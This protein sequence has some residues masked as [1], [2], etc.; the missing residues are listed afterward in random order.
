MSES[1]SATHRSS[2][3]ASIKSDLTKVDAH[4]I[5]AEEY[6]EI[7]ELTDEML[8]RA[9]FHV[10]DRFVRRG[11]SEGSDAAVSVH[12][13]PSIAEH[14]QAQGP[15]WQARVNALLMEVVERERALKRR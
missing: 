4:E 7:P 12:L 2:A 14:F 11:P 10:G 3:E 5:T 15:G 8:Q 13:L 9:E 6:D 1:R